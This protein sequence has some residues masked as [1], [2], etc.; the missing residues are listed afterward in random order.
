MAYI[1]LFAAIAEDIKN[2]L[3]TNL[4]ILVLLGE[5]TYVILYISFLFLRS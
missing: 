3:E 1:L 4:R 2:F 5:I